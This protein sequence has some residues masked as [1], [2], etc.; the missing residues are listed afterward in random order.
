MNA[1][2]T[3]FQQIIEG[4]KQYVVPLFQ[5]PYSWDKKEWD[6]LWGDLME[7]CESDNPRSHFMGSLVTM[8]TTSVPEGVAKYLLIDG[9]Q[10]ITTIFIVLCLMRDYSKKMNEPKLAEEINH[11]L[12]VNPFKSDTDY[13]KLLPTQMDRDAFC[14]IVNSENLNR[15]ERM[16][17][18][19]NHFERK[20]RQFSP[21]INKLKKVITNNLSIVS[22]VLDPEDNPHL[23]FESLNAKGRPLTQADL[24]R[25]FFFMRIHIDNQEE[26]YSRYWEPMQ[27][28]LGENLTEFIR[29]YLMREGSTVKE[30]EVYFCLKE[31]VNS[32]DALS[33]L[34][35]LVRYAKYYQKLLEPSIESDFQICRLLSRLKRLDVT[36][37][38]PFILNCYEDYA[39][40]AILKEE[41][42]ETLRIIENFIIRRFV[43]NV[44][45]NQLN[46]IFPTLYVQIKRKSE[47][48]F[49]E[50][51]KTLLQTKSYPRDTE[52]SARLK[53]NKLYG[54]GDRALKTK[55]VLESIE[56]S[57]NHREMVSF[58]SLTIEHIMP[59]T[60]TEIWQNHIGEEWEVVHELYLH[61][62][63]NLTLTAYNAELSNDN[64]ADKK[65]LL[66][67][68]HLEINK[69]FSNL[70]EWKREDIEK[71]T[72]ILTEVLIKIWPYFG[73]SN[74]D[75][76]SDKTAVT[77]TT[78]KELWILG[79]YF[80]VGSWRDVLQK[81]MN[82]IAELEPD[83]FEQI[84]AE[85]PRFIGKDKKKFRAI[86]ELDNGA[87]I[88]VNLSAQNIQKFCYQAIEA[89]NLTYSDWK[90]ITE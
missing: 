15:T 74:D 40:G 79:Q 22:I 19:Y 71:R 23:V 83:K 73:D 75:I 20:F 77:G 27:N 85:F 2:E 44:P 35:E 64:F 86:R 67:E 17:L 32:G 1:S 81:T 42:L 69:Y 53:D 68:S 10:R 43:C 30:N 52:F 60:L 72:Q 63:G 59:Q 37:A 87:F 54:G 8:P 33:C 76:T 57:Y 46:K 18:A 7:L 47:L 66:S 49:V 16:V 62:L 84:I 36:T 80:T 70:E 58:D 45:T 65:I 39:Q 3:K 31:L 11:T 29:H 90:V 50:A 25:N 4:T 51:L 78:P 61:T 5:R 56:E 88:E 12:L 24:I 26:I 89:I 28:D 34:K 21:D 82:T 41:F 48:K 14:S 13:F 6:M 55:L 38:F 9:Q